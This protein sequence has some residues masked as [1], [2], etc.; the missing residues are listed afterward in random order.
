MSQPRGAAEIHLGLA[1]SD[2]ATKEDLG[3]VTENGSDFR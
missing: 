3:E 1:E 2:G